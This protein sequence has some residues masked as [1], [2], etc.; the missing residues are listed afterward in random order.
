MA[1][2]PKQPQLPLL[3]ES[4]LSVEKGELFRPNFWHIGRDVLD[5]NHTL[6]V[7]DVIQE[8]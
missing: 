6:R 4:H 3:C 7:K 8:P 5:S 1:F 2:P